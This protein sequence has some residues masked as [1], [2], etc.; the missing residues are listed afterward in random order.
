MEVRR[1]Y[2]VKLNNKYY[3]GVGLG[4]NKVVDRKYSYV[5]TN[6]ERAKEQLTEAIN[7]GFSDAVIEI[8]LASYT[9]W[10]KSKRGAFIVGEAYTD[11][12]IGICKEKPSKEIFGVYFSLSALGKTSYFCEPYCNNMELL[13]LIP[14][15]SDL[16]SSFDWGGIDIPKDIGIYYAKVR[17]VCDDDTGLIGLQMID[18]E[19]VSTELLDRIRLLE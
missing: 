16:I 2:I 18:W 19:Y 17:T 5:F 1:R 8:V 9:G 15:P 13:G 10:W 7:N 4:G 12:E 11:K 14:D 6:E 3:G